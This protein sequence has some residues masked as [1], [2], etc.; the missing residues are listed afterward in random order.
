MLWQL[1]PTLK[2]GITP[3]EHLYGK[4]FEL[5]LPKATPEDCG[6]KLSKLPVEENRFIQ[7][8][9]IKRGDTLSGI[10][11]RWG[12][13]V[14]EITRANNITT[15]STLRLGQKLII[16]IPARKRR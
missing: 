6:E 5:R 8:Y 3:P 15:R 13:K 4:A 7:T 11:R 2:Q 16:P 1:N 9:R 14:L 10:A 12:A